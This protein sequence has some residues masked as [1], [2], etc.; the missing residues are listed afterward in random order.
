MINIIIPGELLVI[1]CMKILL[2]LRFF[3][4]EACKRWFLFADE[5]IKVR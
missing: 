5:S 2:K 4:I 3:D 1:F